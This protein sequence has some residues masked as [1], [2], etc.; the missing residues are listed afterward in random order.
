M[1]C[2]LSLAEDEAAAAG[3]GSLEGELFF[4][5]VC[6]GGGVLRS[7]LPR[8]L[9][10]DCRRCAATGILL[11]LTAALILTAAS[12]LGE[13]ALFQ[14]QRLFIALLLEFSHGRQPRCFP[15]DRREHGVR[16]CVCMY[17]YVRR[18]H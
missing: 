18:G 2:G 6:D 14:A 10:V 1:L 15:H 11:E 16:E 8:L 13:T 17:V 3:V 9:L 5:L 7:G 12:F 4:L